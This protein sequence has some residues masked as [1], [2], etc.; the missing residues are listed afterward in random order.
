M[1]KFTAKNYHGYASDDLDGYEA[2]WFAISVGNRKEKYVARQF[3]RS[4]IEYFLP[5]RD[6]AF[7]YRSKTGVRRLPLLPGYLFVKI[8]TKQAARVLRTNFVFGFVKIGHERRR[9]T[10]REIDLLRKIS[11]DDTLEW[12][13]EEKL[14][15]MAKGTPVE[16]R[17]GPLSG[18]KGEFIHQRSKNTFIISFPGLDARLMSC[19][20]SSDDVIPIGRSAAV[21]VT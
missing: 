14:T 9:V 16:I 8:I 2:R 5:L 3:E 21:L 1:T 18:V 15:L 12:V 7:H 10:A 11:V 6:K 13:V 19:E 4:G 17:R 20:V